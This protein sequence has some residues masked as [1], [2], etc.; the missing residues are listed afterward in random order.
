VLVV[1]LRADPSGPW[2]AFTSAADRLGLRS[3]MSLPLERNGRTWAVLDLY[4]DTGPWSDEDVASARMLAGLALSYIVMA[5]EREEAD[6]VRAE[7]AHRALHDDLTGLPS[8]ALLLD[9]LEHALRSA[10]RSGSPVA[11]FF[12]DL[13]RFKEVNDTF[14]HLVGDAVL[15]EVATRM[16]SV[17][18]A[19]D[20]VARLAGDEFVVVCEDLDRAGAADLAD[21]VESVARRLRGVFGAPVHHADLEVAVSASVGAAVSRVGVTAAQL[22]IDADAAMY[23]EK[24]RRHAGLGSRRSARGDPR[25]AAAPPGSPHPSG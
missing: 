22:L 3:A 2:P 7:L 20:S 23:D 5:A 8:R 12:V 9:R 6:E 16:A 18:R 13:D 4:R 10:D 15:A 19:G 25:P 1:D 17:V 11:V 14:G 24:H 21:E